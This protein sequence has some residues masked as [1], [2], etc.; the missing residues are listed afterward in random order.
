MIDLFRLG[1]AVALAALLRVPTQAQSL[2]I[3]SADRL[4]RGLRDGHET[5]YEMGP[6]CSLE[7]AELY[8]NDYAEDVF[9]LKPGITYRFLAIGE[10]NGSSIEL[11]VL[12]PKS[13]PIASD[14]SEVTTKLGEP[15]RTRVAQVQLEVPSPGL[16][17]ARVSIQN[18][19]WGRPTEVSLVLIERPNSAP[20]VTQADSAVW[21]NE[22]RTRMAEAVKNSGFSEVSP[23]D[24]QPPT[25]DRSPQVCW[26]FA[27]FR[28]EPFNV[29]GYS[30]A[31]QLQRLV[32]TAR[33]FVGSEQRGAISIELRDA[34]GKLL[35]PHPAEP[36][37]Q[38]PTP[39][40]IQSKRIRIPVH[41][42]S[43]L[44]VKVA[45]TNETEGKD[46]YAAIYFAKVPADEKLGQHP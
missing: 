27:I 35:Y 39:V 34:A 37:S 45:I 1:F 9:L 28:L 2:A 18:V 44:T 7:T 16:Y 26:F 23:E 12:N 8:R 42:D 25:P 43:L 13:S 17:S 29:L 6:F 31:M 4:L 32:G 33:L 22:Q 41:K 3:P 19:N 20:N 15:K 11:Q 36:G 46:I 24:R 40:A 10:E 5:G 14:S 30:V 21:I 38:A